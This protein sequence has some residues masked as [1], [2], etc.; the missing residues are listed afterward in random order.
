MFGWF[1]NRGGQ[2]FLSLAGNVFRFAYE[3][4]I[5]LDSGVKRLSLE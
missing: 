5:G 2:Y 1:T 3:G 4:K